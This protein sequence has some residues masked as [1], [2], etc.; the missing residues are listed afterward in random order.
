MA[1]QL[2]AACEVKLSAQRMS[3]ARGRAGRCE[4][5]VSRNGHGR[6]GNA[7][8]DERESSKRAEAK[9]GMAHNAAVFT[10]NRLESGL[11]AR[12]RKR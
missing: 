12:L 9:R 5:L 11:Q 2:I 8:A 6:T 1:A 4:H 7:G 3:V 10:A